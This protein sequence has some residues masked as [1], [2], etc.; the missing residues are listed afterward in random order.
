MGSNDPTSKSH[1][2]LIVG[3]TQGLKEEYANIAS[4]W[5]ENGQT[6]R[7]D[8]QIGWTPTRSEEPPCWPQRRHHCQ[9]PI[10]S[11]RI[12]LKTTF[13]AALVPTSD[14]FEIISPRAFRPTVG[15]CAT[16]GCRN[17]THHLGGDTET[18]VNARTG[19][20]EHHIS[21]EGTCEHRSADLQSARCD[22]ERPNTYTAT[23]DTTEPMASTKPLYRPM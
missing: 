21:A 4:E 3:L 17:I 13:R 18:T 19:T 9:P 16:G 5:I 23:A 20:E 22:E 12:R 11:R 1:A 8:W 10:L 15:D 2:D 6:C 14:A 7:T